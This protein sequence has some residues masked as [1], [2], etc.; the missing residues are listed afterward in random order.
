ME[1]LCLFCKKHKFDYDPGSSCATCGYDAMA[2]MKCQEGHWNMHIYSYTTTEQYRA[3][4]LKAE[5]CP[6][7]EQVETPNAEVTGGPKARPVD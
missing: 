5:T 7:Y 1:K 4:L 6:D 3:L 2:A